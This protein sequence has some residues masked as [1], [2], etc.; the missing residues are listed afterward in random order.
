MVRLLSMVTSCSSSESCVQQ[1]ECL[2]LL[3]FRTSKNASSTT[4]AGDIFRKSTLLRN[5]L[6]LAS[7]RR[8]VKLAILVAF[9]ASDSVDIYFKISSAIVSSIPLKLIWIEAA[10]LPVLA[11][12]FLLN[13][14][15]L[16]T[17]F[18][19]CGYLF[20]FD[21]FSVFSRTFQHRIY[22]CQYDRHAFP[23]EIIDNFFESAFNVSFGKFSAGSGYSF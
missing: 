12:S 15:V 11:S 20:Y 1:K 18:F 4:S 23:F 13:L 7:I 10:T 19:A 9:I 3:G 17:F 16:P 2:F 6:I 21:G 5:R 22:V 14:D 8:E